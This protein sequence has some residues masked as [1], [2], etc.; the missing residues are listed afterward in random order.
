MCFSTLKFA[1]L[2][3]Y[4]PRGVSIS[5]QESRTAMRK[6]KND[7]PT[8]ERLTSQRISE[9]IRENITTLP[10]SNFFTTNTIL[11]PIPN[12]SFMQPG[13]L[14]VPQRLANAL[15]KQ[16]LGKEVIEC[17]NRVISLRKAAT[18]LAENRPK[19]VQHYESLEVKE[20]LS[21]PP[22]EILFVDDI[23]TR[24]TTIFGAANKLADVF[25]QA[26]I[27]AFAAMRTI[28]PPFVFQ[29]IYDPCVGTITLD[30]HNTF[31]RP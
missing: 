7:T 13:T 3:S 15:V 9:I 16:E 2:L 23:I 22:K 14:W 12:S 17:L 18:S 20:M 25:P 19:A 24:G 10:F 30:V 5:E 11:V 28:S 27:R 26:R 8:E 21:E 31:R 1:S 29:K 6:L 4:S